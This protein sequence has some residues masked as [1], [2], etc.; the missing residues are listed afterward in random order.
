WGST[1]T[2]VLLPGFSRQKLGYTCPVPNV[3]A[4]EVKCLQ[5]VGRAKPV[6]PAKARIR[7]IPTGPGFRF[8]RE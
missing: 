7:C 5:A 4:P 6:I 2:P 1:P 3:D 8:S